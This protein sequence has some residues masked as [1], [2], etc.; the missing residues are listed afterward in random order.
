M[1]NDVLRHPI[2]KNGGPVTWTLPVERSE[3]LQRFHKVST[4]PPRSTRIKAAYC[5]APVGV[6]LDFQVL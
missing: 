4:I 5:G 6:K 1:L 2:I 3:I